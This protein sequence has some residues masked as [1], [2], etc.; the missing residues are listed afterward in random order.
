MTPKEIAAGLTKALSLTT[1]GRP[2]IC[3]G[4]AFTDKVSG[5]GVHYFRDRHGRRWLAEG[6]WA[7]FR[8]R[9]IIEQ[10]QD[11]G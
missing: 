3:E 5:R 4:Y 7:I 11:H 1:G 8:V 10:E 9:A 2:M 6:P